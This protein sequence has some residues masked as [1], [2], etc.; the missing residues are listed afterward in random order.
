MFHKNASKMHIFNI[1]NISPLAVH[2]HLNNPASKACLME[3][4]YLLLGKQ[5]HEQNLKVQQE[6]LRILILFLLV[7]CNIKIQTTN[8]DSGIMKPMPLS[9][10]FIYQQL[11]THAKLA[12]SL[13]SPSSILF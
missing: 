9:P 6:A 8:I 10:S 3:G 13:L 11:S 12:S 1:Y 7:R 4:M 2:K 5:C